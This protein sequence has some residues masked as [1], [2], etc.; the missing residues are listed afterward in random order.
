MVGLYEN[1]HYSACGAHIISASLQYYS[2][3]CTRAVE[4]HWCHN[5][6][7]YGEKVL[8]FSQRIA[9]GKKRKG[10]K[11]GGKAQSGGEKGE[12]VGC[13]FFPHTTFQRSHCTL[14][15]HRRL[16]AT[17]AIKIQ[18]LPCGSKLRACARLVYAVS[19]PIFFPFPLRR[20]I[21][22]ARL[23]T[24]IVSTSSAVAPYPSA[25][26]TILSPPVY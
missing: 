11:E 2:S 7:N 20:L 6:G 13:R 18:R 8:L 5:L 22:E 15:K 12:R 16:A 1:N 26:L 19:R 4:V 25:L 14:S 24:Y 23:V 9:I 21:K 3:T 17:V 10:S